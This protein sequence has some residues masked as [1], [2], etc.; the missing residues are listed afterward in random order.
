MLDR[1]AMSVDAQRQLLDDV[2]HEL[3]TPITI[4]RGHLEM[5]DPADPHDVAETRDLGIAELDRLS[6]LVDDIRERYGF[7]MV[8][9]GTQLG[10]SGKTLV[11]RPSVGRSR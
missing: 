11:G 1:L 5:M 7:S 6:R 8:T 4:V 9:L 3:K 2:R 10:G